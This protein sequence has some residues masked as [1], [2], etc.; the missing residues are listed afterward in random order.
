MRGTPVEHRWPWGRFRR[1]TLNE[2][3]TVKLIPSSR[4]G[5]QLQRHRHRDELWIVLDDAVWVSSTRAGAELFIP[6]GTLHRV[7]PRAERLLEVA[8]RDFDADDFERL[9]DAYGRG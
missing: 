9:D 6:R 7:G 8:F 4:A 1:C 5:A 3:T 2:P